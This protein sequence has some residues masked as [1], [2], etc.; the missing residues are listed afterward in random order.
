MFA[1]LLVSQL[2]LASLVFWLN[3]VAFVPAGDCVPAVASF[4]AVAGVLALARVCV[5][6]GVHILAGVFAY[7]Y[8]TMR[9]IRLS[10]YRSMII[11]S[12]V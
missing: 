1:V 11:F 2:L 12:A 3:A 10:D 6:P 5:D 9:H 8:C 7:F 4:H